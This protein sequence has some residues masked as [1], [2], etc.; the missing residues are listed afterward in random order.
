LLKTFWDLSSFLFFCSDTA[1]QQPIPVYR[2]EGFNIEVAKLVEIRTYVEAESFTKLS[3]ELSATMIFDDNFG[4]E[5]HAAGFAEINEDDI[6]L[7]LV[8]G[9][10]R[11]EGATGDFDL[12]SRDDGILEVDVC[13]L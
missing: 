4:S 6:D 8:G 1:V 11:F 12:I 7:A 5:L 3:A 9:T 10:G 13:I 2:D